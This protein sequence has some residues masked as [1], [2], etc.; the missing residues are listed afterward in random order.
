MLGTIGY[1]AFFWRLAVS[2]VLVGLAPPCSSEGGV[3]DA[4]RGDVRGE[5][6]DHSDDSIA[7]S[8]KES[9]RERSN[10]DPEEFCQDYD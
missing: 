5:S 1:D 9:R 4:L 3:L 10:Y 6:D 7:N 8:N 2:L